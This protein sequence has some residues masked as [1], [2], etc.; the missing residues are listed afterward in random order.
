MLKSTFALF[1]SLAVALAFAPT[2]V[3]DDSIMFRTMSG[4]MRCFASSNEPSRGGGPLAVCETYA[5][6]TDGAFP[7]AP[8][9]NYAP[10]SSDRA[11][12]VMVN[13]RG[14]L[15]WD[16]GD[17]PGMNSPQD[18]VMEYGKTYRSDGWTISAGSAGTRLTNQRTGHGMFVSIDNVYSF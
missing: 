10:G 3:A 7:Q 1:G 11:N 15:S 2:A 16:I 18:T 13:D 4:K 5:Q 12:I 14:Q 6:E 17:I 8:L 9:I